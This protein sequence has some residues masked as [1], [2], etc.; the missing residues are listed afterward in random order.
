MGENQISNEHIENNKAVRKMLG[1]RGVKPENLPVL[2]DVKKVQRKLDADE[3]K[4][5]KETQKI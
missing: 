4:I 2:E 3:K 5:L 1:E